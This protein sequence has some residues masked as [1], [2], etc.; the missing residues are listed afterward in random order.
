M[1]ERK[2]L[3]MYEEDLANI[4]AVGRIGSKY[5]RERELQYDKCQRML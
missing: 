5:S 3:L 1:D 4:Q 2:P